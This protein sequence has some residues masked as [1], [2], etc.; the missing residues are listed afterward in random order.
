MG[1][2]EHCCLASSTVLS[3]LRRSNSRRSGFRGLLFLAARTHIHPRP[4]SS[5]LSGCLSN[6]ANSS[7]RV[8]RTKERC[9]HASCKGN[10]AME[11]SHYAQACLCR[12]PRAPRPQFAREVEFEGLR[13]NNTLRNSSGWATMVLSET[14]LMLK[15]C[16]HP[17]LCLCR[18][19]C[20]HP[21]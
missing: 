4:S 11:T 6:T 8:S 1:I 2:G 12:R 15:P 21:C 9:P 20:P 16:H 7:P 18:A 17:S 3:T 19:P 5:L 14:C 10:Q 13:D